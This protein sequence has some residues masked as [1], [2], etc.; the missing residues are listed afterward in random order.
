MMSVDEILDCTVAFPLKA[1]ILYAFV[2]SANYKFNFVFQ[3]KC[4]QKWFLCF[5]FRNLN[6]SYPL[7]YTSLVPFALALITCQACD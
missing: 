6:W 2:D 5:T 3:F 7:P 4:S 1:W